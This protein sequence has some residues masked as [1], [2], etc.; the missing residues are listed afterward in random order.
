MKT[1]Q[2]TNDKFMKAKAAAK[3][4]RPVPPHL[5]YRISN[6]AS[7]TPAT[8]A[9]TARRTAGRSFCMTVSFFNPRFDKPTIKDHVIRH[10]NTQLQNLTNR[11]PER[12]PSPRRDPILQNN[13]EP[14]QE[15]R[16]S[17]KCPNSFR[18]R[19]EDSEEYLFDK[20]G[21][22]EFSHLAGGELSHRFNVSP[23]RPATQGIRTNIAHIRE[24]SEDRPTRLRK[25]VKKLSL[26]LYN[27]I[28]QGDPDS[29]K[30]VKERK[31]PEI[32]DATKKLSKRKAG[33]LTDR[34]VSP[35]GKVFWDTS[36]QLSMEPVDKDA[37]PKVPPLK[38]RRSCHR[39][40][41]EDSM[42]GLVSYEYSLTYR[43]Q[44]VS[45]KCTEVPYSE[46]LRSV[47]DN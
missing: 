17:I 31:V 37:R 21:K 5:T 46:R 30:L 4:S 32:S 41:R 8:A 1:L 38:Q 12:Y 43:D 25:E 19:S 47:D 11:S 28:T 23:T 34:D 13:Q 22:G 6:L 18:E 9:S 45:G 10:E 44:N 16:S 14:I 3:K 20:K 15:F 39:F 2:R 35:R 7:A 26:N 27:P 29:V 33:Y 40:K 42:K 24:R 36:I